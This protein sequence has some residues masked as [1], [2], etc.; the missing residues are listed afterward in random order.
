MKKSWEREREKWWWE[1]EW[2]FSHVSPTL[3][4]SATEQGVY[5]EDERGGSLLGRWR[6]KGVYWEDEEKRE[7]TGSFDTIEW[8]R[9]NQGRKRERRKL[10][11]EIRERERETEIEKVGRKR[12]RMNCD[13]IVVGSYPKHGSNI[14]SNHP[15][16]QL[17]F[18]FF[19]SLLFLTS[20][21]FLSYFLISLSLSF[22]AWKSFGKEWAMRSLP[23]SRK[24]KEMDEDGD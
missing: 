16:T 1:W 4:K 14:H 8:G 5:W 11:N 19:L 12:W 2:Y 18:S 6:E 23:G 10:E 22:S 15:L 9:H 17:F 21:F 3:F 20:Y 7:F 24:Q 13:P